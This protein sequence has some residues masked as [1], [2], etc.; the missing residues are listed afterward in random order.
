MKL[1]HEIKAMDA[2]DA[3]NRET[4]F[5]R[6]VERTAD[7]KETDAKAVRAELVRL[8]KT[9][10]QLGQHV[11]ELR[12]QRETAAERDRLELIVAKSDEVEREHGAAA[13]ELAKQQ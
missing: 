7:G 2:D 13:G 11:A 3:A 8:N 9:A 10:D 1:I 5:R 4:H 12:L 6:L